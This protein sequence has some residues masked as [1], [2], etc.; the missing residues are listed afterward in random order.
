MT[1]VT[2]TAALGAGQDGVLGFCNRCRDGF[3][4]WWDGLDDVRLTPE[5]TQHLYNG[6]GQESRQQSTNDLSSQL[7][8]LIVKPFLGQT[9]ARKIT[10][11]RLTNAQKTRVI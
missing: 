9:S 2:T 6:V 4:R 7:D 3:H 8:D 1:D 11:T 5:L 10:V